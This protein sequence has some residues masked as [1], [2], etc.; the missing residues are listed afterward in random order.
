MA[1]TLWFHGYP[2]QACE[3]IHEALSLA[4]ELSHP[5]S[6]AMTLNWAAIFHQFRR[7]AHLAQERAEAAMNLSTVQGF[8]V[9]LGFGTVVWGWALAEQGLGEEGIAQ[10]RQGIATYRA[11][12]A[13]NGRP[14]FLALLAGAYE[15]RGER[16]EGLRVLAEA[17]AIVYRTEE[18]FYEAELYRLRGTLTLQSKVPGPKP[19]VEQEAEEYFLRAIE[20]AQRQQAKSLELR[21]VMNLSRLWQQQG[22]R[23]EHAR[24]WPRSTT[25]SLRDLIRRTCRRPRRCST[26]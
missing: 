23:E 3:K 20:I 22:K 4:G 24:C 19:K 9:W 17:L 1:W 26:S 10:I 8:P 7:E 13:E 2:D 15:K 12:G 21:V 5:S 18:R 25:G 16:E 6:L 14:Y 11:T